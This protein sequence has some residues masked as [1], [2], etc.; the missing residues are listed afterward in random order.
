MTDAIIISQ[1]E[2][3]AHI[4]VPA[5]ERGSSQHLTISLRLYPAR[6]LAGLEDDIAN[7]V[8]YAA[9]CKAVQTEA[10]SKP[11][12][13]IE[14][15]AEEIAVMLLARFPLSA[16]EIE[17]RKYILPGTEYVAVWIRR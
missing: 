12:R 15:L 14:T 1:L 11:R 4:G 7:T 13:L 2:L 3:R 5:A 9:V 16:V 6:G 8:D 17:L 10:E